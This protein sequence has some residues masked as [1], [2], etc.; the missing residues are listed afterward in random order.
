M[1]INTLT[2]TS[3]KG[4]VE[5]YHSILGHMNEKQMCEVVTQQG[6][7]GLHEKLTLKAIH[8]HY[9]RVCSTCL[10]GGM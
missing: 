4:L 2:F 1:T 5:H 3:L 10:L 7:K 9:P 8:E 6:I